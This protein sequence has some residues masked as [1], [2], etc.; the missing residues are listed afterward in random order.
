MSP[1]PDPLSVNVHFRRLHTQ[2]TDGRHGRPWRPTL[3]H[4]KRC[5]ATTWTHTTKR[6][7]GLKAHAV[8]PGSP[9]PAET[10]LWCPA[11]E[12]DGQLSTPQASWLSPFAAVAHAPR[13]SLDKAWSRLGSEGRCREQGCASSHG[14]ASP[15]RSCLIH[16]SGLG[17]HPEAALSQE[18]EPALGASSC[19]P[20]TVPVSLSSY[21]VT[22]TALVMPAEL[23]AAPAP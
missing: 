9:S 20:A 14:M 4:A 6:Y 21:L 8:V 2:L 23:L 18:A 3:R 19:Q 12:L 16:M 5:A 22:L 11:A 15:N 10:C 17:Q 7:P 1:H 13:K